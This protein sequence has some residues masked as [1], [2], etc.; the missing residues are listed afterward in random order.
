MAFSS[1]VIIGVLGMVLVIFFRNK[2]IGMNIGATGNKGATSFR[3]AWKAG[4]CLFLANAAL[5]FGTAII[6]FLLQFLMIPYLHVLIMFLAVVASIH[7]WVHFHHSWCG[8]RRGRVR[9]A[10]IGSS[11]YLLLAIILIIR[12]ITIKP[13][14]PGEDMVMATIGLFFG[15]IVTFIAF[16]TCF[17]FV[18]AKGCQT[19]QQF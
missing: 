3:H 6:L 15:V 10:F 14:Y 9:F 2:I 13:S 7:M 19:P 12:M 17:L 11:F 16:L 18:S 8:N 4:L 1:I 5:F